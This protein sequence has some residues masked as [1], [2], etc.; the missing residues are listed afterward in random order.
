MD[1]LS[2]ENL[3]LRHLLFISHRMTGHCL[4]EDD[5]ERQCVTCGADFNRDSPR[6]IER[7]IQDYNRKQMTLL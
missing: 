4:Y 7:R 6:V 1:Q 2:E 5:G 3:Y